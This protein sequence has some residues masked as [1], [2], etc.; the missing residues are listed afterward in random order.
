MPSLTITPQ[1][2]YFSGRKFHEFINPS[3]VKKIL[4][5]SVLDDQ[6]YD[7]TDNFGN[8]K[9]RIYKSE[10]DFLNALLSN[11]NPR[12]KQK[13]TQSIEYH[14]HS[15]TGDVGRVYP[16]NS[17]SVGQLWRPIRHRLLQKH[18]TDLDI[19]NAHCEVAIQL[20][21]TLGINLPHLKDYT[22]NRTKHLKDVMD[23]F[24]VS[25]DTAKVLF[26]R[27]L[28]GGAFGSWLKDNGLSVQD[29]PEFIQNFKRDAQTIIN[30]IA[31]ANPTWVEHFKERPLPKSSVCSTFF[32]HQERLILETIFKQLVK[33][34]IIPHSRGKDKHTYSAVLCYD[35]I[36]FPKTDTD[37]TPIINSCEKAIK[38]IHGFDLK[39]EIKP[40][41]EGFTDAELEAPAFT[42]IYARPVG[43]FRS[44]VLLSKTI[45]CDDEITELMVGFEDKNASAQKRIM[46]EVETLKRKCNDDSYKR[47][48]E[49]F[50]TYHFA[51]SFPVGFVRI[52]SDRTQI[53][54]K[55]DLLTCYEC[56][57][58]PYNIR[59]SPSK[60]IN[61]WLEDHT[62]RSHIRMDFCPPPLLCPDMVFNTYLPFVITETDETTTH[63]PDPIK[64]HLWR[65]AG[66]SDEGL[67]YLLNWLADMVQNPGRIPGVAIVLK[68]VPGVGKDLFFQKF[69]DILLGRNYYLNTSNIDDLIGTF[70]LHE[71]KM[72]ITLNEASGKDTF[73]GS[74]KLKDLITAERIKVNKKNVKQYHINSCSRFMFFSN[75]DAPVK[76]DVGDRRFVVFECDGEK[77]NNHEYF[78]ALVSCITNRENM[79]AFYQFL[80]ERDI[81]KWV[82]VR[83][84]P[85]TEVYKEL[86]SI[87]ISAVDRFMEYLCECVY[88]GRTETISTSGRDL[89]NQF[90]RWCEEYR[91]MVNQSGSCSMS[92]TK[93]GIR[94]KKVKGV[95]KKRTTRGARYGIDLGVVYKSSPLRDCDD[96]EDPETP[97]SN[98]V[99]MI[100]DITDDDIAVSV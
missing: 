70:P 34:K 81:S 76:V 98:V 37:L 41:T 6:E 32:Q 13:G 79:R 87:N 84:R 82:A 50:E 85:T 9:T 59:G 66:K 56:L 96:D 53:I 71:E 15:T 47:M 12:I 77:A 61:V 23:T 3:Q 36:M 45:R 31:E 92:I 19:R 5:S 51:L 75:N 93:F 35:G 74:D 39:L 30:K 64:D 68:S 8:P 16:E 43:E 58:L 55:A 69:A 91:V 2:S 24:K 95:E 54:N 99:K 10:R 94:V 1:K 88:G 60:F 78:T 52:Y 89:Y 67:E 28:Y 22:I 63:L 65:L 46:K 62:R 33:H 90:K 4:E 29:P 11:I 73:M 17:L 83:D 27:L 42:Q 18:M 49:Y 25:R 97:I 20:F 21:E 80:M 44:G 7:E 14:T 86:Q 48:K 100:D 38:T 72:L 26:I 40:M 57:K